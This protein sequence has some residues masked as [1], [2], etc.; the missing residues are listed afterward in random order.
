MSRLR[1][2]FLVALA[3][4]AISPAWGKDM[5]VV[6]NK[7]NAVKSLSWAEL[8]KLLK[9]QTKKWPDGHDVM[10]VLQEPSSPEMKT[11]LQKIYGVTP[12]EVKTL[13]TN[14]N[15]ARA[16]SVVLVNS[17][18]ALMKVVGTLAGSVGVVDV[19]SITGAVNVVK[20]DGKS[21][22]EPGYPLHGN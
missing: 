1:A 20:V 21:P 4:L 8:I 2:L 10:L 15:H 18:E 5:A 11:L 6:V 19:Y 22:L 13:F 3:C 9:T 12:D 16:G 7:S 17:N 14:A